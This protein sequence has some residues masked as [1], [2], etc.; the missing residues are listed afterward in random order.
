MRNLGL[1]MILGFVF[2]LG[3]ENKQ[4]IQCQQDL[5]ATQKKLEKAQNDNV[6]EKKTS[7]QML[8]SLM[9]QQQED[10]EKLKKQIEQARLDEKAK[11]EQALKSAYAKQNELTR[12]ILQLQ[13]TVRQFKTKQNKLALQL[14]E[15]EKQAKENE[16]KIKNSGEMLQALAAENSK[17]K[18]ENKKLKA[19]IEEL[20]KKLEDEKGGDSGNIE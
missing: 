13:G 7:E 3:C 20:Q 18:V 8:S 16:K 5:A 14:A 17:L 11:H 10:V 12:S 4:L 2:L 1:V 9:I 6:A 15:A 19:M